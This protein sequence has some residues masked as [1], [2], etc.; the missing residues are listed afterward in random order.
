MRHL[1]IRLFYLSY[2]TRFLGMT[3]RFTRSAA[4]IVPLMCLGGYLSVKDE[5]KLMPYVIAALVVAIYY[6][7]N[8]YMKKNKVN[9]KEL[10][11]DQKWFFI[12]IVHIKNI[13]YKEIDYINLKM[14][15]N[16][17]KLF[18]NV[19][20]FVLVLIPPITVIAL[21]IFK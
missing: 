17:I 14:K 2:Y 4:I 6:L 7:P 19:V 3:F 16:K 20:P 21:L 11:Y 5:G 8:Y 10:N 12:R 18:Y 15:P 9:L 1:I 13:D